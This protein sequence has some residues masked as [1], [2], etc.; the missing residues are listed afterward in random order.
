MVWFFDPQLEMYYPI[1]YRNTSYPPVSIWEFNSA[2]NKLKEEGRSTVNED[3]IFDAIEKMRTIESNAVSETKKIRRAQQKRKSSASKS[4]QK[5]L[6]ESFTDKQRTSLPYD[7][8]DDDEPIMPF[9]ELL[10][11]KRYD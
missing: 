6:S 10:D 4:V 8:S 1:P 2:L 11:V 3:I 5:Q 9:D 7:F